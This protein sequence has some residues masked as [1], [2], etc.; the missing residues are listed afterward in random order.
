MKITKS[1]LTLALTA[2]FLTSCEKQEDANEFTQ[3][4]S[5]T[6]A[7]SPELP[8]ILDAANKGGDSFFTQL[9]SIDQ[10]EGAWKLNYILKDGQWEL[11]E[12][13]GVRLD[14]FAGSYLY[15]TE[16]LEFDAK[17]V[18]LSTDKRITSNGSELPG[19]YRGNYPL[20][21]TEIGFSIGTEAAPE[22]IY[23]QFWNYKVYTCWN[24][25]GLMVIPILENSDSSLSQEA[26][27][28][29]FVKK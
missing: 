7:V 26:T 4:S 23:E 5:Q 6:T 1:I 22:D 25:K 9:E 13:G 2:A 12:L 24:G 8:S 28:H 20:Q 19:I 29:F 17:E 16:I 3:E 11:V 15:G 27:P 10:L 18:K 21:K 14:F